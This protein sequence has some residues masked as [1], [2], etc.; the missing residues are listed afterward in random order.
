MDDDGFNELAMVDKDNF[1]LT[2]ILL[3]F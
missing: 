3:L 2:A 1:S